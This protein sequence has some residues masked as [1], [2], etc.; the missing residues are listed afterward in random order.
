[1]SDPAAQLHPPETATKTKKQPEQVAIHNTASLVGI[2]LLVLAIMFGAIWLEGGHITSFLSWEVA[3]PVFGSL[4]FAQIASF[5]LR[6]SWWCVVYAVSPKDSK[7]SA[8]LAFQFYRGLGTKCLVLGTVLPFLGILLT[9][10]N[11]NNPAHIGSGIHLAYLSLIYTAAIYLLVV[12]PLKHR[13]ALGSVAES[14]LDLEQPREATT[15]VKLNEDKHDRDLFWTKVTLGVIGCFAAIGLLVGLAVFIVFGIAHQMLQADAQAGDAER[16]YELAQ[17]YFHG[18]G[19]AFRDHDKAIH[20][21]NQSIAQGN[22]EA[23]NKMGKLYSHN[24]V[25]DKD[26]TKAALWWQKAADKGHSGAMK[27]LGLTYLNGAGVAPNPKLAGPLLVKAHEAGEWGVEVETV[28]VL[29]MGWGVRRD[30]AKAKSI[31]EEEC[32]IDDMGCIFLALTLRD[33]KETKRSRS[34]ITEH[35]ALWDKEC[36]KGEMAR[37]YQLAKLHALSG[38]RLASVKILNKLYKAGWVRTQDIKERFEFSSIANHP[39]LKVK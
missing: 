23:L 16:Q 28:Q 21:L 12:T 22:P 2:G 11:L 26:M 38:D 6:N 25:F 30:L 5:G 1:M 15:S 4:F 10:S 7:A 33:L 36:K 32:K 13:A 34:L 35:F 18:R 27:S 37:C 8:T 24:H 39:K 20:W 3:I 9:T 14:D 29:R 31:A 17:A 19:L